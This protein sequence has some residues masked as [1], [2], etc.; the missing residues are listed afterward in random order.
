MS[1]PAEPTSGRPPA[2][3]QVQSRSTNKHEHDEVRLAPSR[4]VNGHRAVGPVSND[5]K[6]PSQPTSY[7]DEEIYLF[8]KYATEARIDPELRADLV[9]TPVATMMPAGPLPP[10]DPVGSLAGP[11]G[12][13][14]ASSAMHTSDSAADVRKSKRELSQSKRAA[15]N[16]AAQV[17]HHPQNPMATFRRASDN[18]TKK[19]QIWLRHWVAS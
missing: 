5:A 15:Q 9:R 10:P 18:A 7:G 6:Y 1:R 4:L 12:S 8:A 13:P 3:R 17:S 2:Q 16:R 19:K 11:G 14:R